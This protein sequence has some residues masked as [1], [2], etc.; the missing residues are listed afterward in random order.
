MWWI[1]FQLIF[2]FLFIRQIILVLI[3]WW[4]GTHTDVPFQSTKKSI[5]KKLLEELNIKSTDRIFEI[6]SGSG[7]VSVFLAK[8]SSAQIVGI[9]KNIFLHWLAQFKKTVF[10]L[11][12]VQFIH[13]DLTDTDLAPATIIYAYFSP[14][15]FNKFQQ[16]FEAELKKDTVFISW[17][18]PFNSTHFN[19]IKKIPD[20]HT[21]YIY[22]KIS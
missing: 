13:Q 7:R 5:L 15:A 12:N 20:R 8:N 11:R 9:E 2:I 18:Y 21:M 3:S 22:R 16:K 1:I 19:L 4:T 14:K 17:R 10:R 6:G